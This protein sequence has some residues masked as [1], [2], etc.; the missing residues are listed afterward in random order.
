VVAGLVD[1]DLDR[2]MAEA[3][4]AMYAVKRARHP[5][6]HSGRQPEGRRMAAAG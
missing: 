6:H 2:L 5:A 1:R 3:D 4:R